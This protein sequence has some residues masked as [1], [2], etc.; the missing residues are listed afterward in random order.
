MGQ[1]DAASALYRY[2]VNGAAPVNVRG[3]NIPNDGY[4]Y[5][6]IALLSSADLSAHPTIS[7]DTRAN[8]GASW[9]LGTDTT[10]PANVTGLTGTVVGDGAVTLHWIDPIAADLAHLEVT[11]PGQT[12][13]T[14]AKGVQTYAATGLVN[15][16]AIVFTVQAVDAKGN[17]STGVTV[18]K[19]PLDVTPPAEVTGLIAN[20]ADSKIELVWVDP[21][22]PDFNHVEITFPGQIGGALSVAATKQATI[23]RSLTNG[24]SY[25]FT[26]KTVDTL[27]NKSAGVTVSAIPAVLD[28]TPT[29]EITSLVA[30]DAGAHIGHLTWVDP[31]TGDLDHLEITWTGMVTPQIVL[32]GVQAFSTPALTPGNFTFNVKAVD[33]AGNKSTG[34][35]SSLTAIA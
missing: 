35:N 25:V 15:G 10:A 30:T 34:V 21:V 12:A 31:V 5:S 1:I 20:H 22:T 24:T 2:Y 3:L 9:T 16:S 11:W 23:I 26:V 19:T 18:S 28:V 7:V 17:R 29:A 32:P 13:I 8:T 4:Y 6:N 27:G 33:F 14:V